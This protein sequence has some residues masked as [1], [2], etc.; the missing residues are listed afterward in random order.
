MRMPN[1]ATTMKEDG[2][3]AKV[4]KKHYIHASGNE[5][6]YDCNSWLWRINGKDGYTTLWAAKYAAEN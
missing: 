6:C 5:I 4:G 3:W 1:T 2:M